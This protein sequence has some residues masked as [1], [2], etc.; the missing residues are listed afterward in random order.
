MLYVV[1]TTNESDPVKFF[2]SKNERDAYIADVSGNDCYFLGPGR[3][4]FTVPSEDTSIALLKCCDLSIFELSIATPAQLRTPKDEFYT[5]YQS[6]FGDDPEFV[7]SAVTVSGGFKKTTL[8]DTD[9]E[10]LCRVEI[11]EKISI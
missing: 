5:T 1:I 6:R 8:S 10:P 9:I 7:S 11:Y 2:D 3:N 4:D